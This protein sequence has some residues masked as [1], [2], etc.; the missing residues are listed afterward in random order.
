MSRNPVERLRYTSNAHGER[1]SRYLGRR[2]R[3]LAEPRTFA[4]RAGNWRWDRDGP[5]PSPTSAPAP[6]SPATVIWPNRY[7]HPIAENFVG[8]IR[9]G[10]GVVATVAAAEIAQP[11]RGIVII[12]ID[13]GYGTKRVALDWDDL[14]RVNPRCAAEVETYFK[15]Q[16]QPGGYPDY[17]N[18]MPG[19]YVSNAPMLYRHWCRLRALRARQPTSDV[20]GRFGL[21]ASTHIRETAIGLLQSEQSIVYVG[22]DRTMYGPRYL[23]EMAR[24]RVCVDLPGRGPFCTRLVDCLAM[25]CC[26]VAVRHAA[27]LPTA[28]REGVEIVYCEEDLSD[29][30]ELCVT[31]VRDE[32]KRVPIEAAAAR[33]FDENLH[34]VRMA[35]SY[36]RVL[37][38]RR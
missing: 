12:E 27:E 9:D 24:A 8:A 18:V 36:L 33:Y 29:L 34:P 30:V 13:C 22:G 28:L 10:F 7:E 14:P 6:S 37:R 32:G 38:D 11:Y 1:E 21:R 19:G 2:L 17:P 3:Y 25:G 31:Y 20:F 5:C 16:Y 4:A 35:Q 23:R 26:V 15:F